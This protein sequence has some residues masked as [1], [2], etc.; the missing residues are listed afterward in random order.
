MLEQLTKAR[1]GES[2]YGMQ[3][4]CRFGADDHRILTGQYTAIAVNAGGRS[5]APRSPREC[6]RIGVRVRGV[7][8]HFG[9]EDHRT[10]A[11]R[12]PAIAVN[13]GAEQ[14]PRVLCGDATA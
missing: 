14:G 10:L 4:Q 7:Q 12:Y 3:L 9:A 6:D 5:R 11:G 13:A 8:C 1:T 2:G